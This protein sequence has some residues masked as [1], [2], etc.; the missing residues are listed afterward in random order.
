[1]RARPQANGA[2]RIEL[3]DADDWKILSRMLL[4]A[5]DP[6]FDLAAD[7]AGQ[8]PDGEVADDWRD[9]V[10]PDL[11]DGFDTGLRRVTKAVERGFAACHGGQGTLKGV[12]ETTK[13]LLDIALGKHPRKP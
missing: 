3:D 7:V 5:H 6:E 11:R 12:A 1:M 8:M 13:T 9:F 2:I 4:D 10:I